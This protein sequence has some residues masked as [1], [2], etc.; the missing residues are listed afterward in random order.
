M[1]HAVQ[2]FAGKRPTVSLPS[3]F[4]QPPLLIRERK[5]LANVGLEACRCNETFEGR[6]SAP[7]ATTEDIDTDLRT[8]RES[9]IGTA[10]V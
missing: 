4:N 5:A 7:G 6:L 9:L 8:R 1:S 10:I 2:D 3:L